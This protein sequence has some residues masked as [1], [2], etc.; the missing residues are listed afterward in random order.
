MRNVSDYACRT[1]TSEL[2]SQAQAYL[3][4]DSILLL[5]LYA[6]KATERKKVLQELS[7]FKSNLEESCSVS[8]YVISVKGKAFPASTNSSPC[9]ME[10]FNGGPRIIQLKTSSWAMANCFRIE[11]ELKKHRADWYLDSRIIRGLEMAP[12]K[13]IDEVKLLP[14]ETK[15]E[16]YMYS[17]Q[18]QFD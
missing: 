5:S 12:P 9:N 16:I 13:N 18:L 2:P 11:N 17:G 4:N 10:Q 14:R 15:R 7:N 8:T 1:I 6:T 3:W